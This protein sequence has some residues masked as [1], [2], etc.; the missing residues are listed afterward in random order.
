MNIA[1]QIFLVLLALTLSGCSRTPAETAPETTAEA[2]A[3]ITEAAPTVPETTAPEETVLH[4]GLREDGSFD[5]HTLFLGDSMTFGL[6][7][8]EL[9]TSGTLGDARYAGKCGARVGIYHDGTRMAP[10]DRAVC[11][12]S[13][14]FQDMTMPEALRSVS[15]EILAI[16]YMFG[17]NY[18]QDG[19]SQD[20]VE[21]LDDILEACPQATVYLQTVPKGN[22]PWDVINDRIQGAYDHYAALGEDRVRLLDINSAAGEFVVNDGIHQA[23]PGRQLWAQAIRDYAEQNNI[24]E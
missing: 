19:S 1:R 16:Y 12:Y 21:V 24:A 6:V 8:H 10:D 22:L 2:T 17:T 14:E 13:E 23:P 11:Y 5:E 18:D 3:A 15:E 9:R 20:Y 4:S 7:E